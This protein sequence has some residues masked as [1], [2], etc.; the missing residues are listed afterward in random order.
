[1]QN[2][3]QLEEENSVIYS[4]YHGAQ[5]AQAIEEITHAVEPVIMGWRKKGKPVCI[6]IDARDIQSQ[7]AGARKAAI[8][9]IDALDYDKMAIFGASLFI[10]HVAQFLLAVAKKQER[11]QYFDTEEQAREW[12]KA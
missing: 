12:L 7:D 10:K 5:T 9:G 1:M 8:T 11:V 3:I 6:L 4:I 2:T